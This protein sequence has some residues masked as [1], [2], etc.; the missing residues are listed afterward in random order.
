M[1]A[2]SPHAFSLRK[3]AAMKIHALLAGSILSAATLVSLPASAQ[4]P[5][6]TAFT[7]V[8]S[9]G[10]APNSKIRVDSPHV[11]RGGV[12]PPSPVRTSTGV[13]K[14]TVPNGAP[15]SFQPMSYVQV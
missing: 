8:K 2:Q 13:Y 3:V 15:D 11:D 7:I 1:P 6:V 10:S 4:S 9:D 5:S 14:I 12:S